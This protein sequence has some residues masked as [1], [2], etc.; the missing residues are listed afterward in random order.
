M[1]WIFNGWLSMDQGRIFST[2]SPHR[3][4]SARYKN[5]AETRQTGGQLYLGLRQLNDLM[6]RSTRCGVIRTSPIVSAVSESLVINGGRIAHDARAYLRH[7]TPP[8]FT[9]FEVK[10]QRQPDT[11]L[12]LSSIADGW[13]FAYLAGLPREFE[14]A[15]G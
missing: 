4:A 15:G 6:L 12:G 13:R 2:G 1:T 10:P 14:P 8:T 5:H 7:P 3:R 9:T 11:G